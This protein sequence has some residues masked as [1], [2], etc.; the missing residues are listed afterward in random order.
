MFCKILFVT[1]SLYKPGHSA[2]T[3]GT[4]SNYLM[5]SALAEH[6]SL[7]I[8]LLGSK[9]NDLDDLPGAQIIR[10]PSPPW[11]G[12]QLLANWNPYIRKTTKSVVSEHGPFDA[13]IAGS[14]TV[15]CLIPSVVGNAASVVVIRA[16]ENF[17]LHAPSVTQQTKRSL[18]KQAVVRRFA[19]A[20]IIRHSSFVVTNSRY[21][22]NAIHERF[23]CEK[24]KIH[25]IVQKCQLDP[26]TSKPPPDNCVGF[27]NRSV[28]KNLDFVV[29][30]ATRTPD[31]DY[32]VYGHTPTLHN[33][34]ANLKIKGWS[35]DRQ[36]MF[37]SAKVWLVPS[38]WPEPFGRV[39]IEAQAADRAA[40]VHA[41][42][43]LPETVLD[44]EFALDSF[45]PDRWENSIR[46]AMQMSAEDLSQNGASIREKFSSNAHDQSIQDLLAKIS[47]S[48]G[49]I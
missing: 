13:V 31:I 29:E 20:R 25:V 35:N 17:G 5:L 12:L 7:S 19:D 33:A 18:F 23:A 47:R 44:T 48:C 49:R 4:I 45:D 9:A 30:M 40:I 10:K 36:D 6:C 46:K 11:S 32:L 15:P 22:Y 16:F 27:V 24:N 3:G 43:G 2:S 41:I 28:D 26:D 21:M 8:L 38:L 34:P 39:A 14:D 42:G 1:S 37:S